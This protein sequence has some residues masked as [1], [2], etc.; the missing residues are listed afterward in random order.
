MK[1][2]IKNIIILVIVIILLCG[3]RF[4]KFENL[5]L[6]EI[7]TKLKDTKK[8]YICPYKEAL[9]VP[10]EKSDQLKVIDNEEDVNKFVDITISL[11]EKKDEPS[12]LPTNGH[13]IYFMDSDDNVI[14]SASGFV[15][16]II[17]TKYNNYELSSSRIDELKELASYSDTKE[18]D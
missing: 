11:D 8:I 4:P 1:K 9:T 5:S 18:L 2:K 15:N 16:Y 13:T 12:I 14:I 7:K 6:D 3:M 17:R 10:C